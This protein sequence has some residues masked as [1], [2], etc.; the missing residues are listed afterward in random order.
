MLTCQSNISASPR[1]TA[2]V[3]KSRTWFI[4]AVQFWAKSD[5]VSGPE[6]IFPAETDTF[7]FCAQNTKRNAGLCTGERTP[8]FDSARLCARARASRRVCVGAHVGACVSVTQKQ[9]WAPILESC[10]GPAPCLFS[11]HRHVRRAAVANAHAV[12]T[13]A[14]QRVPLAAE[15]L[16]ACELVVNTRGASF[17]HFTSCLIGDLPC[18]AAYCGHGRMKCVPCPQS[19][20][21][22]ESGGTRTAGKPRDP[23]RP[24]ASHARQ[25]VVI[26]ITLPTAEQLVCHAADR[27]AKLEWEHAADY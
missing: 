11:V 3:A 7:V 27:S 12:R 14:L 16:C 23:D 18:F 10:R 21:L 13:R 25:S 5:P 6:R 22:E 9:C 17:R 20:S 2:V 19:R 26:R 24:K 1:R 8:S 15:A 4:P